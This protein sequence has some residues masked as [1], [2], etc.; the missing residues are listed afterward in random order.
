M[1]LERQQEIKEEAKRRLNQWIENSTIDEMTVSGSRLRFD[2]SLGL[3][4]GYPFKK[5]NWMIG[6]G[7]FVNQDEFDSN[8]Y[9]EIVDELYHLAMEIMQKEENDNFNK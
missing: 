6:F 2:M 8:E 1:N 7:S 3:L 4:G 5:E 9:D